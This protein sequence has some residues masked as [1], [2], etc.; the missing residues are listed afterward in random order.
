MIEFIRENKVASILYAF[1]LCIALFLWFFTEIVEYKRIGKVVEHNAIGNRTGDV[2]HYYTVIHFGNEIKSVEG[3]QYYAM[4]V[5]STV[6]VTFK[7][8]VINL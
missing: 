1:L 2:I 4:P 6:T 5:G 8:L 3:L 7:K